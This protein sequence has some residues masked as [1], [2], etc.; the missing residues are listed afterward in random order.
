MAPQ[1]GPPC[2]WRRPSHWED[3]PVPARRSGH[4][5]FAHTDQRAPVYSGGATLDRW[6]GTS[7]DHVPCKVG[8]FTGKRGRPFTFWNRRARAEMSPF[9][10]TYLGR[11]IKLRS[12]FTVA[13]QC[14]NPSRHIHDPSS[15][16]LLQ[17][18]TL[19]SHKPVYK[20]LLSRY[21][22]TPGPALP[23]KANHPT[24]KPN[25]PRPFRSAASHPSTP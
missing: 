22:G 14:Q 15:S 11:V 21:I 4:Q 8:G 16:S 24:L 2:H 18:P 19:T 1:H 10:C 3:D 13:S 9:H 17:S 6:T 7:R 5:L 20:P 23:H 12:P 25:L